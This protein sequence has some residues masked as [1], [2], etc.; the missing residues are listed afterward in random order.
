MIAFAHILRAKLLKICQFPSYFSK[1]S[2]NSPLLFHL[3]AESRLHSFLPP[4]AVGVV[5]FGE[6]Y[7]FHFIQQRKR[8]K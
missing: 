3:N 6:A 1:K 2:P 4:F 7:F 8:T 5:F